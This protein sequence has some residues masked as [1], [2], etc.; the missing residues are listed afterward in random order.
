MGSST[1]GAIAFM[2]CSKA[3]ALM[4]GRTYVTPDDIKELRHSILRH[5]IS[6]NFAAVADN[7][8]INKIIDAIFDSV[9][10]P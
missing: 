4:N 7:I 2:E 6:L 10:T 3:V 9:K 5:R 8:S 1:R